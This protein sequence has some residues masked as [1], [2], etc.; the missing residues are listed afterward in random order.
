MADIRI[1]RYEVDVSADEQTFTITAVPSLTGAFVRIVGNTIK[2]SAG[3]T[4]STGN[5]TPANL[6]CAAQLSA[7]DT[8]TFYKQNANTVK[9]MI[10]VWS[11]VGAASGPYEFIVRGRGSIGLPNGLSSAS[12]TV[13]GISDRNRVIPIYQGFQ[14]TEGSNGDYEACTLALHIN[15]SNQAVFSR[16]NTGA[17]STIVPYYAAVEFTGSTW[18]VGHGVDSSHDTMGTGGKQVTLNTDSTGVGGST[19]DVVSWSNAMI[20]EASMEGDGGGETGL[21]DCMLVVDPATVSTQVDIRFG[22]NN[23][24]NDGTCYIHVL[25]CD[26]MV[27]NRYESNNH[28]ENNGGAT[29][30]T[31]ITVSGVNS[32]TPLNELAVEAFVSTTGTGTAWARGVLHFLLTSYNTVRNYVHRQGNNVMVRIGVADFS[33]MVG[34]GSGTDLTS[35]DALHGHVSEAPVLTVSMTLSLN[36]G[37]HAQNTETA[38]LSSDYTLSSNGSQHSHSAENP[39][40]S[41]GASLSANDGAHAKTSELPILSHEYQI[42]SEPAA[43]NH[44]STSPSL[45][46]RYGLLPNAGVHGHQSEQP[47][48]TNAIVIVLNDGQHIQVSEQPI[49]DHQYNIS[50]N[51][52]LHNHGSETPTLTSSVLIAPNDGFNVHFVDNLS[53]SPGI[54]LS[55]FD[56]NHP[57]TSD[58]PV[59]AQDFV[60]VTSASTISHTA[61]AAFV[62]H[63]YGLSVENGRNAHTVDATV[64]VF[65]TTLTSYSANHAHDVG[66]TALWHQYEI[67]PNKGMHDHFSAMPTLFYSISVLPN[68]GLHDHRATPPDLFTGTIP[69]EVL[70]FETMVQRSLYLSTKIEREINKENMV[71]PSLLFGSNIEPSIKAESFIEKNKNLKSRII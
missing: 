23:A 42:T 49:L 8:V 12:T 45:Q 31:D 32:S 15:A 62:S 20:L 13:G 53:I 36:D 28:S 41:F 47:A 26:D 29:Y 11:Y 21:A 70:C 44:I 65:G 4:N 16:N 63:K 33:A 2:G 40:L 9:M 56:G 57:Q 50:P 1:D 52:S 58:S 30:G 59:L 69:I 25:Q 27:V 24:R 5:M 17:G 14:T 55:A 10:E 37:L 38:T 61:S 60:L 48:L 18:T 68:D 7:T 64:L 19:F 66:S 67:T 71:S 22:D 35:N 43:H 3:Q 34:S 6:G 51:G 39:T 46:L 54:V